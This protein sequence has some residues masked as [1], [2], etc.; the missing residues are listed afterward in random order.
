MAYKRKRTSRR[1][2][3]R[4][5]RKM[6]RKVPRAISSSD[7]GVSF[8]R[9]FFGGSWAWNPAA[10]SGF[11]RRITPALSLLPNFSEYSALFDEFKITGIKIVL[12]PR[13]TDAVAS[14]AVNSG[15]FYNQ[16]YVTTAVD[17]NSD[18]AFL[19]T[20]TYSAATYNDFLEK[21]ARPKSRAV[22]GPI[23]IFCRPKIARTDTS[24][25]QMVTPGWLPFI[26]AGSE[27]FYTTQVFIHDYT[28][29][30]LNAIGYG[31][32]LQYTYYFKCRGSA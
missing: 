15:V 5:K 11:W 27:P 14:Q 6:M 2:S 8:K 23:S 22:K 12:H 32:D 21:S 4:V 28:F 19:P 9:T 24:M 3:R 7:R 20:G 31:F 18:P 16:L 26:S 30:G 17:T 13:V 10:T 25:T 29:G 1:S